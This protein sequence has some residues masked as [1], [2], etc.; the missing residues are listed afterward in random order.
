LKP[1][2]LY[3]CEEAKRDMMAKKDTDERSREDTQYPH[4]P[5]VALAEALECKK[6]VEAFPIRRKRNTDFVMG[7]ERETRRR[8]SQAMKRR[9]EVSVVSMVVGF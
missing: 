2:T 5:K 8:I 3:R 9:M 6:L 4:T 7:T 1:A